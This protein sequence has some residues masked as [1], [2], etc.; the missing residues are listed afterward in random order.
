MKQRFFDLA[1]QIFS[2]LCGNEIMLLSIAAET[3]DFIR[4]NQSKVRQSGSVEQAV[5]QLELIDGQ[6]HA[7]ANIMLGDSADDKLRL[8]Q[9]LHLLREY[10]SQLP[11]DPYLL[12]NQTP[13]NSNDEVL[14]EM[15]DSAAIMDEIVTTTNGLD[16]VG[17]YVGGEVYRGFANSLGQRNWFAQTNYN[18]NWCLYHS[19]DKAVKQFQAGQQ[20][21]SDQFARKLALGRFQL[22]AFDHPLKVLQPGDYRTYL[23]PAAVHELLGFLS[24]NAFGIKGHKRRTTPLLGM[25]TEGRTLAPCFCATECSVQGTGARFQD[26]GFLRPDQVSLIKNGNISDTLISPRSAREYGLETNGA[27]GY[28]MPEALRI[29]GGDLDEANILET[30]DTGLY[31]SNLWYVNCSDRP[32]ARF[33][34]MT[35]FATVWVEGGEIAAPVSVMRF[36]DSLYRM[37]GS[38]LE[39][40]TQEPEL[41]LSDETYYQR[42]TECSWMPG[43]L[44]RS[45]RLTL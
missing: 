45:F 17:I 14:S 21:D 43:A 26:Q 25:I 36:D 3:S 32:R 38:E 12:Y 39:G 33:T 4:F 23:S 24:Y 5:V 31:V 15:P 18:L 37:F 20:W 42:A 28:E 40:L 11:D 19:S 6:R 30:L 9:Q 8:N 34:G 27:N 13:Q 1:G 2:V 44:L 10:L 29:D 7:V 22:A 16:M 41:I 35:R